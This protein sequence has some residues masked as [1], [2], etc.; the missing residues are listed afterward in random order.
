MICAR[1]RASCL[2]VLFGII[3][4]TPCAWR[5]SRQTIGSPFAESAFHSQTA[6]GPVSMPPLS[7]AP[8]HGA[9]QATIASGQVGTLPS[10]TIV[11]PAS[12]TQ[13][14]VC[15]CDT[16]KAA[17]TPMSSSVELDRHDG[18]RRRPLSIDRALD[19]H[20]RRTWRLR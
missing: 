4:R 17:N 14:A 3:F 1:P 7:I 5:A 15:S 9:S 19:A 13:T 12:T 18:G 16:S 2:S 10:A 20:E 8:G 6:S 11:P